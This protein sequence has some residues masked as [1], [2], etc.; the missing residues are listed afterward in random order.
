MDD[1]LTFRPF[2]FSTLIMII[3]GWGGLALILNFSIPAVIPRWGF[4]T[5]LIIAITGTTIPISFL[6]N[7][8]ISVNSP[9]TS[10]AIIRESLAVGIYFALLAWMSIWRALN[11]PVAV[12]IGL[13]LIVIEYLIRLWESSG[14]PTNDIP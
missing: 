10:R 1:K 4:F 11:F 9:V 7:T 14:K 6:I 12:W 2:L 5:L 13:G 8:L 3:G